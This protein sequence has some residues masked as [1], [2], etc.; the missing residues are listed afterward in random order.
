MTADL[1]ARI[2]ADAD[3]EDRALAAEVAT[4]VPLADVT[5]LLALECGTYVTVTVTLG[6][7]RPH[8]TNQH[9]PWASAFL[10]GLEATGSEVELLVY[11]RPFDACS[12]LLVPGAVLSVTGRVDRR[13]TGL[14]LT[15]HT[16][17]PIG[18]PA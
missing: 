11:P 12:D 9:R 16:I 1:V 8:R 13:D 4:A 17:N 18:V 5:D 10:T 2:Y 14:L 7:V 15:A 3:A 6:L